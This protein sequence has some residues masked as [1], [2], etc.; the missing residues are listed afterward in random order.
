M[1]LENRLNA[2]SETDAKS[3][4]EIYLTSAELDSK[5]VVT[6][7]SDMLLAGI[8]TVSKSVTFFVTYILNIFI[9]ECIHYELHLVPFGKESFKASSF[10]RRNKTPAM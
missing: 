1:E 6:M 5:D 8:D 2:D 7:V 9:L 4:L 10:I 3:L